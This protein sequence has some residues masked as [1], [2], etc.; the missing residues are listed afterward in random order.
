MTFE[1]MVRNEKFAGQIATRTVGAL[2]LSRPT[3]V[4]T[5]DAHSNVDR[6]AQV[7]EAAHDR[8]INTGAATLIFQLAVPFVGFEGTR[9]TDVMPDFAI[10]APA[11]GD[12]HSSW[13]VM[14]D[15]KDYER[16]RSR[17]DDERMLKGFLQVAVGAESARTWS[18]L[19]K[20]MGVHTFGVLA[21]PKN[22]FFQP[23][24]VVENL[25][26]YQEEVKLRIEER[27]REAKESGHTPGQD[28]ESLVQHLEAT[29]DPA[30][31][32]SCTLFSYCRSELRHSQTPLDLLIEL[33]VGRDMRGQALGLVD[34]VNDVGRVP[35][36]T[37]ANIAAT[38]TGVAQLTGQRRVDP[39]GMPGTVNV[40]I[41]KSDSAPLDVHGIGVQ[42]VTIDGRAEWEYTT[43]DNPQS[44]ET[45]RLIVRR[46]GTALNHAMRDQRKS[47]GNGIPDSVHLVVPDSDTADVLVSIADN[48]AGIELSRLRWK[49]DKDQ[50][51][52][53]LTYDGEPATVPRGISE[54]ER[55]AIALLLEDDR[56]RAFQLRLPVID[57][58]KVLARRIVAGGPSINSGRL[59][60]LVG[61][62]EAR[63]SAPIDHR[64]F[65]D[66]IEDSVHTSGARL[67][68]LAS[69]AIHNAL[70]GRSGK[71]N[72]A[73]VAD[74]VLY[75]DLVT[76]EL[77][78]K[79][80]ILERA[81]ASL[82]GFQA[83]TLRAVYRAIESDAQVVWRRRLTL[84]ASDLV[85]FGRTYRPWRNSLVPMIESDGTCAS[86]LFAL[87]NPQAAHDLASDAGNRFVSFAKVVSVNPLV[88]DVDSRRITA[89]SR[90]V[91]LAN[92]GEA[93]AEMP[94]V[95]VDSSARGSFKIDGLAIGPL[96]LFD[97]DFPKR[98]HWDP[99]VVPH[100]AAGDELVIAD[101][102]WFSALKGN[103]ILSVQKPQQDSTSAPKDGCQPESYGDE[104]QLHLWCCRP[105]ED[106][107]AEFSDLLAERR[108]RGEL[109]PETWPPV[110]DGDG[111]EVAA[112][113]SAEGNPFELAPM[114]VP[115][116]LTL[117]DLE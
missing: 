109:N 54:A 91:L 74:P 114:P 15:A 24:P 59:D 21:V 71:A 49:R 8:A 18:R 42:R 60:Y 117:D 32:A 115:E 103:K 84:H 25:H 9:A 26:D 90:V 43:F 47:A 51:R 66:Q 33:G 48:L 98:L 35:A 86:Q 36:S 107:E 93:C 80:Q 7:L 99:Q 82:D 22:A 45:R 112:D 14:G 56:A 70:V 11:F 89:D 92:N 16:V 104:P 52:P 101:F 28:I 81:L 4:V 87:S 79:A 55:T 50:G 108:A 75:K 57:L 10:V 95:S 13:L 41:A 85:R 58:R 34:G 37:A 83:S 102:A 53:V 30:A 96:E 62:A 19:P 46:I 61:W 1:R 6:T 65:A 113:G 44:L 5:V 2:S 110:R 12:Q 39:A 69:D 38:L 111:F 3:E 94:G 88:I 20:D 63:E 78:Y 76:E 29:F 64:A 27:R 77:E 105:H 106:R 97:E 72:D 67:T 17:I 31:C 23:E 40:V 100:V 73:P 116:H 68:S